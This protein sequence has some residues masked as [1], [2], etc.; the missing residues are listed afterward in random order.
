MRKYNQVKKVRAKKRR[1]VDYKREAHKN[2]INANIRD[3][4]LQA[5]DDRIKGFRDIR[6][7]SKSKK[8]DSWKDIK[9]E[10]L[11]YITDAH[12]GHIKKH[13]IGKGYLSLYHKDIEDRLGRRWRNILTIAFDIKFGAKVSG[14]GK[15]DGYT[16]RYKLK[17]SVKKVCDDVFTGEYKMHGLVGRD[18]K[19]IKSL[20]QYVVGK[21]NDGELVKKVDSGKYNFDLVVALNQ[22]NIWLMT[23]MWSDLYKYKQG[24]KI[25][26]DYWLDVLQNIRVDI[27][28]LSKA[29][30]ERLHNHSL[31]VMNKISVD[32]VGEGRMLQLYT[33]KDSG[34]LYGDGWLNLQT[35]PKE[36]RYIAMAGMGYY[37]YDMEN[38]HYNILYQYNRL[39]GGAGLDNIGRYIKDTEGIRNKIAD[40]I[41]VEVPV[42][43]KIL[44]SIIYGATIK[45]AHRYNDNKGIT[46]DSAIYKELLDYTNN[47]RKEADGLFNDIKSNKIIVGLVDDIDKAYKV[48]QKNW[49]TKMSG[50]KERVINCGNKPIRIYEWREKKKKWM[51]KSKGKLLSH[52]LQGIEAVLLWYIMEEENTGNK[53][54]FI[55]AHH[56]GWVSTQNWEIKRLERVLSIKS[57]K[58]LNDYNGL[59]GGFNIKLKKVKLGEVMVGD[60]KNKILKRKQPIVSV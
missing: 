27:N 40:D 13:R 24:K 18:G 4:L 34:R 47:N 19:K 17:D 32:I 46:E 58:L 31:E 14:V 16:Y 41:G 3:D 43:K 15:D 22:D 39:S 36:M 10:L 53:S 45:T 29:K 35:M 48:I 57:T 38:A 55:M 9:Y 52:F 60:W 30:L 50:E 26:V 44:I 11:N 28:K 23:K 7:I 37:E 25:K 59:D 20:P 56:D 51:R 54:S 6:W 12:Y 49:K 42:I 5:L 1:K 21:V 2:K 33:E 8:F